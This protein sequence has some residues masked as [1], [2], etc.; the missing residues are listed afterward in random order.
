MENVVANILIVKFMIQNKLLLLLWLDE[1]ER[2]V[3]IGRNS[4]EHNFCHTIIISIVCN[5]ATLLKVPH[6]LYCLIKLI[7][8]NLKWLQQEVKAS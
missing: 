7:V 5:F 8:I 6:F 3:D 2:C 4:H 1:N